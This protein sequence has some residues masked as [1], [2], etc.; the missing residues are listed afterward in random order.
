MSLRSRRAWS[1]EK[2]REELRRNYEKALHERSPNEIFMFDADTLQISYANDHALDN[3]GYSL[4]Q[5]HKKNML[6]LHPELGIESFAAMIEP[7]RRGVSGGY[8][9]PDNS[10][11]REWQHLSRGGQPAINDMG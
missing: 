2:R 10:G 6:A 11:T 5:L 9:I 7:L 1:T 8:Q 4:E 3:T